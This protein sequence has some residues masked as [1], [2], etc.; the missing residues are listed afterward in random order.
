M[1]GSSAVAPRATSSIADKLVAGWIDIGHT[2]WATHGVPNETNAHPVATERVAVVHNGIIENFQALRR[3][4]SDLGFS[5]QT[6]TDTEAVAI[7]VTRYLGE[8]ATPQQA[9][10]KTLRR[11]EG[12]FALAML[13]AGEEDLLVCA[14]RGSPLAIGIG[15]GEMFIGSD[16]PALAPLTPPTCHLQ[17]GDASPLTAARRSA[18]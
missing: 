8:G 18:Y 10:A 16:A 2:R 4:L 17:E 6:Q 12:A 3:E 14:R 5:F 15:D 9:V 13:F 7:M 1:G 11:L